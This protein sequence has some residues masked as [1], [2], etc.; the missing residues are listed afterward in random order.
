MMIL[1][2]ASEY[3]E[4]DYGNDPV[5]SKPVQIGY[6]IFPE[7]LDTTSIYFVTM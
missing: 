6:P 1:L 4:Q 5:K 7:M 3:D 2:S